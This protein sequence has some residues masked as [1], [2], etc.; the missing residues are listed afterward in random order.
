[1][2]SPLRNHQGH[3]KVG[4]TLVEILVCIGVIAILGT[5]LFAT[6]GGVSTSRNK[7]VSTSNIR[8]IVMGLHL[9]SQ[10]NAGLLPHQYDSFRNLDW[11]GVLVEDEYLSED[12]FHAP[13][14]AFIRRFEGTPRSY[15][16]NSATYTF[17]QNGYHSP[18][19][20]DRTEAPSSAIHVPP[21]IMLVGE[22]FGGAIDNSGAI[23]GIAEFEGLNAETYNFYDDTGAHYGMADGSVS[24]MSKEEI[25]RY[26]ADTDYNGDPHDP[27][28]WKP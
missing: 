23:V 12:V 15:A 7:T 6:L 24:F 3:A 13:G 17:L 26:R 20:R 28:K 25:G 2:D 8:Q 21:T 5:L 4:F 14:D 18:W 19:P 10:N 1:M 16:V 11:S 9:Y 22:N 27:W